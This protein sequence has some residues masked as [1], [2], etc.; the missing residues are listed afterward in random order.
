MPSARIVR[1]VFLPLAHLFH[2]AVGA[3][4]PMAFLGRLVPVLNGAVLRRLPVFGIELLLLL[5]HPKPLAAC[6]E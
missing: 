2:G 5:G 6:V 3:L 1:A 4:T